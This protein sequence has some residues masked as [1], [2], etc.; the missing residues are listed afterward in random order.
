MQ[1]QVQSFDFG[2][3]VTVIYSATCHSLFGKT[4]SVMAGEAQAQGRWYGP[5][6]CIVI[7]WLLRDS[8]HCA[9]ELNDYMNSL[10]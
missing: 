2:K 5:P 1:T 8:M 9:N 10:H 6:C 4:I 3:Q 7:N